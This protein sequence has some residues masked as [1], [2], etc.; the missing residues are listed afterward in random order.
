MVLL[1][2]EE[3]GRPKL[4]TTKRR[5]QRRVYFNRKKGLSIELPA[6]S[7][8]V[9]RG[10]EEGEKNESSRAR[11]DIK[12]WRCARVAFKVLPPASKTRKRGRE[13]HRLKTVASEGV[14]STPYVEVRWKNGRVTAAL[15][16]TAAQWS[17]LSQA[18][19]NQRS[20]NPSRQQMVFLVEESQERKY[21]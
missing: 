11:G 9:G 15:L 18:E 19:P 12:P 10:R 4:E 3:V 6:N 13:L 8:R 7:E 14:S 17:L 20:C 21:Q 1:R 5:K 2:E 16:D